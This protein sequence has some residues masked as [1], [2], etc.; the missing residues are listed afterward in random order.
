MHVDLNFLEIV[1]QKKKKNPRNCYN[2]YVVFNWID[3]CNKNK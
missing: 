2:Y 3:D 1:I